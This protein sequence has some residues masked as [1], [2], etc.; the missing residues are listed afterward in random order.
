MHVKFVRELLRE[1]K[2]AKAFEQQKAIRQLKEV[3]AALEG[4]ATEKIQ[5]E[6]TKMESRLESCKGIDHRN[7]LRVVLE[8][9]GLEVPPKMEAEW[10]SVSEISDSNPA[11]INAVMD[12]MRRKT[13]VLKALR[14]LDEDL[15]NDKRTDSKRKRRAPEEA[16][17][18]PCDECTALF[19]TK[20]GKIAHAKRRHGVSFVE[21]DGGDLVQKKKNR[22]GQRERQRL[23]DIEDKRN[24]IFKKPKTVVEKVEEVLHPSW[25]AMKKKKEQETAVV[26]FEGQHVTFDD[27]DSE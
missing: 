2:K 8:E 9:R 15:E 25:E 24:G 11:F 7:I 23:K 1:L 10:K 26:P 14:S 12:R 13:G 5:K 3:N 17:T 21:N 19:S 16:R 6:I 27:S 20:E 4:D 22:T 18:I